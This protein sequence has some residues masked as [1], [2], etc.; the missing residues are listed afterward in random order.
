MKVLEG[1]VSY[2]KNKFDVG[3]NTVGD[4]RNLIEGVDRIEYITLLAKQGRLVLTF[5]ARR[6]RE[7]IHL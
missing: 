2:R 7:Q 3:R 4:S 5:C 6:P 1:G